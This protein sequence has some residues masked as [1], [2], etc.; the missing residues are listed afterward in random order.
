MSVVC[1]DRK[2]VHERERNIERYRE[3]EQI[4]AIFVLPSSVLMISVRPWM[5]LPRPEPERE[6]ER[7]RERDLVHRREL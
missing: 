1:L 2:K 6:R 7:E 3:R 4:P 5:D